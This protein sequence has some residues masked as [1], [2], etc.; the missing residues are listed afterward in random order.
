MIKSF[1]FAGAPPAVTHPSASDKGHYVGFDNCCLAAGAFCTG[2]LPL[3][4]A[5]GDIFAFF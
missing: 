1:R 2:T 3:D 4:M 5:Y